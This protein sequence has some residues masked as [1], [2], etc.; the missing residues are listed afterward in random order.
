MC[1]AVLWDNFLTLRKKNFALL[2]IPNFDNFQQFLVI[3][4]HHSNKYIYIVSIGTKKKKKTHSRVS[5]FLTIFNHKKT[6]IRVT[7]LKILSNINFL[8]KKKNL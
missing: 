2:C 4:K 5:L 1:F 7:Y 8:V 6:T 3:K